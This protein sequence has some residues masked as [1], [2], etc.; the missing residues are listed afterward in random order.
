MGRAWIPIYWDDGTI[1]EL[2]SSSYNHQSINIMITYL[3]RWV[4]EHLR[5]IAISI[6]FIDFPEISHIFIIYY[7]FKNT[8]CILNFNLFENND[9]FLSREKFVL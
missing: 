4:V 7:Y 5:V 9:N 6:E 3:L 8:I 1:I 2:L